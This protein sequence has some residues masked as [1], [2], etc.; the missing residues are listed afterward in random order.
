MWKK[1]F[2]INVSRIEN[3]IIKHFEINKKLFLTVEN[4]S[5]EVYAPSFLE[6]FIESHAVMLQGNAGLK[7]KEGEVTSRPWQWPINYRGQFFSG[8]SYRI[9][10]LG[11][12]I[13]WWGNLIFL[14]IFIVILLINCIKLQRGYISSFSGK[15][16]FTSRVEVLGLYVLIVLY[17]FTQKKTY[18]LRVALLRLVAPL[19]PILGNGQ[20]PLLPPLFPSS[21]LQLHVNRHNHG[22]PSRGDSQVLPSKTSFNSSSH[23]NS[24]SSLKYNVQLLSICSVGLRNERTFRF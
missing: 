9:Y 11:N 2:L 7:P 23:S 18:K 4:V 22:L 10:L 1:I 24:V 16:L 6:R 3:K 20:S 15:Y 19:R 14:G 13:I 5:F 12:P 8:S 21:T 17:R